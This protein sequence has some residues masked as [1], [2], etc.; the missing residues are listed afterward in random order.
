M[1]KT[2]FGI[3]LS[4]VFSSAFAQDKLK[5]LTD[6]RAI[7]YQNYKEAKSQSNGLFG[8]KTSKDMESE[9][10]ILE[11]IIK[12]DNEILDEQ[13]NL[14]SQENSH[15]TDKYNDLI[16]QNNDLTEKNRELQE[17]SER[18]KGWS[19]ENH[20]MLEDTEQQE[21]LLFGII[22][23]LGILALIFILKFYSLKAKVKT[24]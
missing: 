11:E 10:M 22:G 23:I 16:Q 15:N 7:L 17:L 5:V 8:G 2:A 9:I 14:H 13:A 21:A 1:K 12:K 3:F 6:Q 24:L 20:K 19:K 4:L 18:H